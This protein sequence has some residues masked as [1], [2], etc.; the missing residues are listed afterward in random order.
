MTIQTL[1][2][3]P[4]VPFLEACADGV[5]MV[6]GCGSCGHRQFY[7]RHWCLKCDSTDLTWVRVG[8]DGVIETCTVVRRPPS[9][10]H[11][12][13]VPY[14]VAVVKLTEGPQMMATVINCVPETVRPGQAVRFVASK[15]VAP[16]FE[17][18]SEVA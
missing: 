13:R 8:G 11:R 12:N 10:A 17:L 6:Q 9:D 7:P 18:N 16:S 14:V 2:P 5:L 4:N 1:R 3:D 15:D